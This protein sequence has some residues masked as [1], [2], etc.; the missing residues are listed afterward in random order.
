MMLKGLTAW[1][2]I[3]CICAKHF[4]VETEGKELF[5]SIVQTLYAYVQI[6]F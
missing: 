5:Q 1:A 2:L 4:L 6:F 3:A